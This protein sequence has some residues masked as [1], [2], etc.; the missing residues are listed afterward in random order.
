MM[1]FTLVIVFAFLATPQAGNG[2]FWWRVDALKLD[3]VFLGT[4]R[5]F[6]AIASVVAIWL[7]SRQ[8][9][10]YSVARTLLWMSMI[11][12]L[13]YL[14]DL[15]IFYGLHHWTEQNLGFGAR[16]IIVV[17]DAISS[18]FAQL[19][20][21]PV[22]TLIAYH[23]PPGRQAT[24]FALMTAF[25]ALA[26]AFGQLQGKY[27]NQILVVTRGNYDNLGLLTITVAVLTSLIP[28]IVIL[29]CGWRAEANAR[30]IVK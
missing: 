14:P 16:S 1:L 4:A 11:W 12:P 20:S 15:G 5:Q 18:P 9:T 28:V 3:E 7:L 26:S 25:T 27:L 23:A 21:L 6:S 17:G 29:M 13:V 24:W 8:F 2:L 22:L 19:C 10:Q 30:V